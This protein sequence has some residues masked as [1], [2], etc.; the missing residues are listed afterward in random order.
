MSHEVQ[1][2]KAPVS[3]A[4]APVQAVIQRRAFSSQEGTEVGNESTPSVQTMPD[5]S[6]T[7]RLGHN[8][9]QISIQPKLTIGKPGDAY[10]Q[11]ADSTAAKV[12]AMPA[13]VQKQEQSLQQKPLI[14]RQEGSEEDKVSPKPLAN[15]IQRQEGS[16]EDKVSPKPLANTIQRQEGPEEDKVSPKPLA[17]TI[18]RMPS[19]QLHTE[20]GI[21]MKG[22]DNLEQTLSS[23]K[24]GGSPL[25]GD[26][27][28]F[29]GSRFGADFSNVR[30]HTDSTAQAMCKDIGAQAFTHGAD[31]YYGAGKAPGNNELTAHELTHTIQ[32]GAVKPSK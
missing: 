14:Q 21:Q 19:L 32:Q 28:S 5:V 2:Q 7:A 10:E 30:V 25:P 31:V 13:P 11:E 15:T 26:T 22:V 3:T 9:S 6:R 4:A 18:Q 29:M 16:E 1:A 17:N 12:M 20:E 24:G 27:A 8:F 23:T